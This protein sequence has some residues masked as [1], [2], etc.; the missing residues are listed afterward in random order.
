MARRGPAALA[1][2]LL[3]SCAVL[4]ASARPDGAVPAIGKTAPPGTCVPAGS[5]TSPTTGG[6]MPAG[7]V[8]ARAAEAP[9]VLLG[10]RHDAADHHRWQLDTV[11][12][13]HALRP[14]MAI[15]LEMLPRPAQPALD[16]WVAGATDEATFLE[17]SGWRRSWGFDPELYLPILRFARAE[18]IPL[19]A[20]NVDRE[21][22]RRVGREG[23]ASVPPA[24][25]RGIGDPAPAL[26]AYRTSLAG[27]LADHMP[28][29]QP[30]P[31]PARID[32]FVEAQLLWDRAM[33]EAL[34]REAGDGAPVVGLMGAGHVENGFGVPH[35]LHALGISG[36]VSLLPWDAG[37][38]CAELTPGL[39]DAV[40]GIE[41][42]PDP[43]AAPQARRPA[44]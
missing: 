23:W 13:L 43:A 8:M 35:Q 21:L 12:A 15:G 38:P 11:R 2:L 31:D 4:P 16:R 33:A 10:E 14:G 36:T 1:A 19:I 40:Y 34:A 37:R 26:P 18:R 44:S 24:D 20:L 29:G 3:A 28:A 7:E 41:A 9:V 6:S 22:V 25:R 5:W 39:A 27:I 42:G 32:R 17:E 30:G